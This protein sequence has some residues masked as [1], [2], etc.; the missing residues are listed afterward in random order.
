MG[1]DVDEEKSPDKIPDV[2]QSPV[3]EYW[4]CAVLAV[5]QPGNEYGVVAGK[6]LGPGK[7]HQ[8]ETEREHGP[9][10]ESLQARILGRY[11]GKTISDD[12]RQ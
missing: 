4:T 5:E 9:R 6:Q 8:Y 7:D 11:L 2:Y 3:A 12:K 10:K 1:H